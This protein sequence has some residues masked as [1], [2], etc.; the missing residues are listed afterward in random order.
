MTDGK[1]TQR[2]EMLLGE[3]HALVLSNN[4]SNIEPAHVA[5][6]MLNYEQSLLI[7]L[8]NRL[9]DGREDL[10]VKVRDMAADLPKLA[11]PPNEVGI[12]PNAAK[13]IYKA[14]ALAEENKTIQ[15]QKA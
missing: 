15:Q 4:H 13:I 9:G 11:N 14:T 8:I 10:S 6:A 7:E 5:L 12:G 3:A 1:F 2:V